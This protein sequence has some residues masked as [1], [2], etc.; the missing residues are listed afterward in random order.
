MQIA[1]P[2]ILAPEL[3]YA[4]QVHV[5]VLPLIGPDSVPT[6]DDDVQPPPIIFF[7]AEHDTEHV[8]GPTH[9]FNWH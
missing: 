5:L 8:F 7:P 1:V 4:V 3:K 9:P 6:L 2:V